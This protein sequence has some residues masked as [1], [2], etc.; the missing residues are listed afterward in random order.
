MPPCWWRPWPRLLLVTVWGGSSYRLG[1]GRDRL[2]DRS[3]TGILLVVVRVARGASRGAGA[4]APPVPQQR[5]RVTNTAGFLAGMA[6]FGAT[7]YLP[8]FLQLVTG[9]S[10]TCRACCSCR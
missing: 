6:M 10:P 2:A 8:L 9:L 3:A 1:L 5:V 4:A 7:V